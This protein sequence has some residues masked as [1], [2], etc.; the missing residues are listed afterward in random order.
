MSKVGT[1]SH[2]CTP[3]DGAGT[4]TTIRTFTASLVEVTATRRTSQGAAVRRMETRWGDRFQMEFLVPGSEGCPPSPAPVEIPVGAKVLPMSPES[5]VTCV[6]GME[7]RISSVADWYGAEVSLS[8]GAARTRFQIFLE[9]TCR[10]FVWE[11]HRDHKR[12]RSITHRVTTRPA[13][14]PF[15]AVAK[16]TGDTQIVT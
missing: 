8:E 4:C 16:V 7:K 11:F 9:L 10:F 12:P 5:T 1:S 15:K 13:V 2:G 14:V 6:S 3:A